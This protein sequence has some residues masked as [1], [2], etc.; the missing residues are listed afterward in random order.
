MSLLN[1]SDGDRDGDGDGRYGRESKKSRYTVPDSMEMIIGGGDRDRDPV[2]RCSSPLT[3]IREAL[4]ANH[5]VNGRLLE[6]SRRYQE[7]LIL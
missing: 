4:E 5:R 7:D 2:M 6:L 1:C 3:L